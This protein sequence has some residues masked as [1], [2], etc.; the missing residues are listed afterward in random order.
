VFDLSHSQ[1]NHEPREHEQVRA[2]FREVDALF[3]S[4]QF[5]PH[6]FFSGPHAQTLA[7]YAWPRRRHFRDSVSRDEQRLFQVEDGIQ[8]LAKCR[9]QSDR[10][11]HATVVIWHGMEGSIDSVYMWSMAAKAFR[12]GFNVVRVNYRNCGGTEHLTPTLYHGGMSADLAVVI[13]ELIKKEGLNRIFPIGFSL[14]GNMVLKLAGEY[15]DK[16]PAEITAACVIS[17]SVDL[18]VSNDAI[19]KGSNW[20]YHTNFIRSLK[21]RIRVKKQLYPDLYDV[22]VLKQIKTIRDFDERFTSL[23]HGFQ[24]ADD[25]YY[26]SS[27]VRVVDKI[28]IPTLIIHSADDPFIPFGPLREKAFSENPYLLLIATSRGGHVAFVSAASE[29]EDRFWAENRVIEF[30]KLCETRSDSETG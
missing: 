21:K 7:A 2:L 20:L 25:Y 14:G 6:R 28:Q 23:A 29:K 17:P 19:L 11:K 15:A 24:N 1:T 26:R 18:R 8:V 12:A 22:A 27:S 5:N 3:A 10:R 16:P 13:N 4:N 30:C 9:W